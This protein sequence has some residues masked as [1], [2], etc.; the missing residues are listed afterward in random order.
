MN[1]KTQLTSMKELIEVLKDVPERDSAEIADRKAAFL[2]KAEQIREQQTRKPAPSMQR[3]TTRKQRRWFP[4]AVGI[5]TAVL[6][7][8]GSVGGTVYAAQDSLP[9]DF[10]YPVKIAVEDARLRLGQD[11]RALLDLETRFANR[12]VE[13]INTLL[14]E[15]KDIPVKTSRRLES[16]LEN[17]L[18]QASRLEDQGQGEGTGQVQ[19]SLQA[20][21]RVMIQLQS[22]NPG[23]NQEALS[24][25]QKRIQEGI[26]NPD[27]GSKNP[28]ASPGKNNEASEED[29]G[30]GQNKG[31]SNQAPGQQQDGQPENGKPENPGQ[32]KGKQEDNPGNAPVIPP[33][34]D[35]DFD[36][37]NE[38]GNDRNKN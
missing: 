15:G 24:R 36:P 8:L 10:L 31:K 35:F 16:H 6:L 13:E 38:T 30:Q 5:L 34:Q 26:D 1:P 21:N 17:M 9:D 20:M 32:G 18:R 3:Q 27:P 2:T 23:K 22:N 11:S 4:A 25:I 14:E 29:Q 37:G 12:R 7:A 19:R 33:G 28:D